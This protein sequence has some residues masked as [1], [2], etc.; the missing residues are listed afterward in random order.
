MDCV[1]YSKTGVVSEK[2]TMGRLKQPRYN[3]FKTLV[4][5]FSRPGQPQD[6]LG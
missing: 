1:N 2:Y 6:L 5:S 4:I 3:K